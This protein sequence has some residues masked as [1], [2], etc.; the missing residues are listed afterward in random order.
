MTMTPATTMKFSKTTICRWK[1]RHEQQKTQRRLVTTRGERDDIRLNV[2]GDFLDAPLVLLMHKWQQCVA[3]ST[4]HASWTL[5][6]KRPAEGICIFMIGFIQR[7]IPTD[8]RFSSDLQKK[9]IWNRL[10]YWELV[11]CFLPSWFLA[12]KKDRCCRCFFDRRCAISTK[13]RDRSDD[14]HGK[15]LVWFWDAWFARGSKVVKMW[16][17]WNNIIFFWYTTVYLVT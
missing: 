4:R 15:T 6:Q 8:G 16:I 9:E 2:V 12:E 7:H 17:I 1:G 5:Q 3:K 11:L 10:V 13:V 14:S